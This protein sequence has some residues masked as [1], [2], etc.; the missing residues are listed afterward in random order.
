MKTLA[1]MLLCAVTLAI[2]WPCM[3]QDTAAK[4]QPKFNL[5]C[6]YHTGL[7]SDE[8]L[9]KA[10]AMVQRLAKAGYTGIAYLDNMNHRLSQQTPKFIENQKKF[11]QACRDAK[12]DL[13]ATVLPLGYANDIMTADPNLAEGAPV[14]DSPWIVKDGKLVS[15]DQV[16]LVNGAFENSE[17]NKPDGWGID[18][19]GKVCFV[20]T[21]VKY[22]GKP[23]IRMEDIKKNGEF[24]HARA[25]Q[26]IKVKPFQYY[27]VSV[28]VKTEK[29]TGQDNRL[30]AMGA[31]GEH[32]GRVLN[33][34]EFDSVKKTQDWTIYH[35]TFNTLD[36]ENVAIYVGSWSGGQG[37]IWFAD[38][39]LEPAGL[40]DM[41]RRGGA[42]FKATSAD[43]KTVYEEGK[44]LPEMK[45][46]LLGKSPYVGGYQWHAGPTIAIPK[47]SSLKDGDKVLLSYYHTE[48][49]YYNDQVPI[50]MSE[51]KTYELI[52]A[53]VQQV[54]KNLEPDLWFME[55]DEIRMQG[56]DKSCQDTGKTCG[57]I[58][59][60]NIAKCTAIIKKHSPA[61]KGI[62]V[63]SDMFDPHQ[64]AGYPKEYYA[65]CKGLDPWSKSWEGLPKEVGLI[66]WNAGKP[67]SVKFFA[68]RGHAQII[69]GCDGQAVA[70]IL[71][72]SAG[73][74]GI[75]GAIY[76]T[77][78]GDFS[79]NVENFA[80]A[81]LKAGQENAAK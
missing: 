29:Y 18:L 50:C 13:V 12:I 20:D 74:K 73:Q 21:E 3:A 72:D 44:D 42:P 27:H 80:Q 40:S 58:L 71:K 10:I 19:P 9:D 24:E 11:R 14:V 77:W 34:P 60:D 79:K 56:W 64:N 53:I 47:G 67:E 4:A 33:I 32:Q 54:Q 45:D 23:S 75:S 46:P 68:G 6:Y 78:D 81:V 36:Y 25:W 63:W 39:K 48:I 41:V 8:N 30:M 65:V 1:T 22:N 7:S 43:G 15:D 76:V 55:H 57:E 51:P 28:A 5:W 66:N 61:A 2:A 69:S 16:K 17:D 35:K 26:Q 49:M 37:K 52:D 62:Y 38:V 31:T 59:A 70:K